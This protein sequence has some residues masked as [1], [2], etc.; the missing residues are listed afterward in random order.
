MN[1]GILP[2]NTPLPTHVLRIFNKKNFD[3]NISGRIINKSRLIQT[4]TAEMPPR[5]ASGSSRP[6]ATLD[7][8]T[9]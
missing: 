3:K 4:D 1:K 5:K 7:L 6:F 8:Q 9:H 2:A